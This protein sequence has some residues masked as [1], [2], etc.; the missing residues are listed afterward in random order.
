VRKLILP[1]LVSGC[2][3]LSACQSEQPVELRVDQ[4][5]RMEAFR[6]TINGN[7]YDAKLHWVKLVSEYPSYGEGWYNLGDCYLNLRDPQRARD[8]YQQCLVLEPDNTKAKLQL[9][10]VHIQMRDE[11]RAMRLLSEVTEQDPYY[12]LGWYNTALMERTLGHPVRAREAMTRLLELVEDGDPSD[13][14]NIGEFFELDIQLHLDDNNADA[15]WALMFE[16]EDFHIPYSNALAN[17]MP[18]RPMRPDLIDDESTEE[19]TDA[20]VDGEAAPMGEGTEEGTEGSAEDAGEGATPKPDDENNAEPA[21]TPKP[22]QPKPEGSGDGAA[23][24]RT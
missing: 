2:C 15:A 19:G 3:I 1:L 22:L 18:A 23:T 9:A 7:W 4:S 21:D 20:P 24:P 12:T 5:L 10:V 8:S 11:E 14:P 16:M 17:R 13:T 6:K